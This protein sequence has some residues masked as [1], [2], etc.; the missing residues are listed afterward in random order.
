MSRTQPPAPATP[1]PR[2]VV[3]EETESPTGIPRHAYETPVF[4]IRPGVTELHWDTWPRIDDAIAGYQVFSTLRAEGVIPAAAAILAASASA[5]PPS[6]TLTRRR[7]KRT[8]LTSTRMAG[9][10]RCRA[11]KS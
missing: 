2:V 6:G 8:G 4:G 10:S 9:R 11:Q 3:V 5:S 7:L 1:K